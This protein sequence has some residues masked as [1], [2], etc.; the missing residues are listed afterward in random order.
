MF[1][2]SLR[3]LVILA[4][5]SRMGASSSFAK[6]PC[7]IAASRIRKTSFGDKSIVAQYCMT[8]A[9]RPGPWTIVSPEISNIPWVS[10]IPKDSIRYLALFPSIG[11]AL[12]W[13]CQLPGHGSAWSH[14][15]KNRRSLFAQQV[16]LLQHARSMEDRQD[17]HVLFSNV[18]D[19]PIVSENDLAYVDIL[20][21]FHDPTTAWEM[22]KTTDGNPK[23]SYVVC[24]CSWRVLSDVVSYRLHLPCRPCRPKELDPFH[25]R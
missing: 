23:P 14:L 12:L 7:S 17:L 9:F 18:I 4:F 11:G 1:F 13:Y 6:S 8:L 19:D 3:A 2:R 25:D 22:L 15:S 24:R 16:V 5:A 20:L 10:L 21:V